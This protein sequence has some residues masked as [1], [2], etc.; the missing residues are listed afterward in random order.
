MAKGQAGISGVQMLHNIKF[1]ATKC[2]A[3]HIRGKLYQAMQEHYSA[4][5]PLGYNDNWHSPEIPFYLSWDE[6]AEATYTGTITGTDGKKY[7]LPEQKEDRP[8]ITYKGDF[9]KHR[10]NDNFKGERS[11]YIV[12]DIDI[13]QKASG[14]KKY[15]LT[16][17]QRVKVES[18]IEVMLDYLTAGKRDFFFCKKSTSGCGLHVVVK[19]EGVPEGQVALYEREIIH[20][21]NKAL[22]EMGGL[23]YTYMAD[24]AMMRLSQA[25]GLSKDEK[26]IYNP[27]RV[28]PASMYNPTPEYGEQTDGAQIAYHTRTIHR[29]DRLSFVRFGKYCQK[30]GKRLPY[31]DIFRLS[32]IFMQL[33]PEATPSEYVEQMAGFNEARAKEHAENSMKFLLNEYKKVKKAVSKTYKGNHIGINSLYF[34]ME[35][36]GYTY[37]PDKELRFTGYLQNVEPEITK[38]F[39]TNKHI[40]VEAPT[41]SGKTRTLFNY[42]KE[43]ARKNP[44]KNYVLALPYTSMAE[45]FANENS[46]DEFDIGI[47][48]GGEQ[49]DKNLSKVKKKLKK[50]KPKKAKPKKEVIVK[51]IELIQGNLFEEAKRPLKERRQNL[52]CSTYDSAIRIW[53]IET[54]VIDEA[55]D[56]VA[57]VQFRVEAMEALANIRC[58]KRI[59]ITATPEI[60]LPETLEGVYYV[61]CIK[62]DAVKPKL[63]IEKVKGSLA[64]A[65]KNNI[66]GKSSS[67]T[68]WNHKQECERLADV[69]LTEGIAAELYN[70]DTSEQPHQLKLKKEGILSTHALA[71]CYI[72]EGINVLNDSVAAI[73]I[74]DDYSITNIRQASARPRKCI[75][76]VK[77]VLRETEYNPGIWVFNI[78]REYIAELTRLEVIAQKLTELH[79]AMKYDR[80]ENL[81]TAFED[82][83]QFLYWDRNAERYMV[84]ENRVKAAVMERYMHWLYHK[85]RD[86]WMAEL[87]KHFEITGISLTDNSGKN[88]KKQELPF[89]AFKNAGHELIMAFRE[90]RM[91]KKDRRRHKKE[92]YTPDMVEW[93]NAHG[94]LEFTQ[95]W[96]KWT[97]RYIKMWEYNAVDYDTI[98]SGQRFCYWERRA[99]MQVSVKEGGDTAKEQRIS[100]TN[101]AVVEFLLSMDYTINISKPML[102]MQAK[103]HIRLMG[104][105]PVRLKERPFW[106][107]L[108]HLL[109]VELKQVRSTGKRYVRRIVP[110]GGI[111]FSTGKLERIAKEAIHDKEMEPVYNAF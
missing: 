37:K 82:D 46:D 67:L 89:E 4:Q 52:W 23:Y 88:E 27:G 57:Q 19:L 28:T 2:W 62:E 16:D 98:E 111:A 34:I 92:L 97:E 25:L 43:E 93:V 90:H 35:K 55:H 7:Y 6:V 69:L 101:K 83:E 56:M 68:F 99:D 1:A 17:E 45:Q 65:A 48:N 95:E 44:T 91:K 60:L 79:E 3:A 30:E 64:L 50:K 58:K 73:N 76:M 51:A 33:W 41:G 104:L 8:L 24:P 31:E 103:N 105:K 102:Y 106:A 66:V 110:I 18:D 38:V 20:Q 80:D 13:D 77:L 86:L 39:N 36:Y 22:N 94:H 72:S 42:L 109:K 70:R 81:Y 54:L 75:P 71:T 96:Q 12:I 107:S 87:S 108:K 11:P 29:F 5:Y 47:L 100:E 40:L 32:L 63:S 21:F 85:K 53:N 15:N 49:A 61:R 78:V 14:L 26:A 10:S 9:G 74:V 84:R 59:L